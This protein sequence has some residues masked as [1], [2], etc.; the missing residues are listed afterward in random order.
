MILKRSVFY[1]SFF[2]LLATLTI[3]QAF[4]GRHHAAAIDKAEF[5]LF[6]PFSSRAFARGNPIELITSIEV[7]DA[8]CVGE[9]FPVFVN[10]VP[11]HPHDP[12]SDII[13]TI[14]GVTG[15]P[16]TLQFSELGPRFIHV[17]ASLQGDIDTQQ[18]SINIMKCTGEEIAPIIY[19]RPNPFQA[20]TI[21]FIV[22]DDGAIPATSFTWAF[23][24]GETSETS[25][26]Y[27][28]HFYGDSLDSDSSSTSFEATVNISRE[29][30][31][32]VAL[33]KTVTLWNMVYESKQQGFMQIRTITGERASDDGNS[34]IGSYTITNPEAEQIF[35]STTEREYQ[36]CDPN[37]PADTTTV[38][39][40]I[41]LIAAGQE[42]TGELT[43]N[44]SDI[45]ADICGILYR[46]RGQTEGGL[47]ADASLYFEIRQNPDTVQD[48]TNSELLD[49]LNW[50]TE[51]GLVGDED[52]VTYED[53]YELSMSGVITDTAMLM[54]FDDSAAENESSANT[55][56]SAYDDDIG[57][58]CTP[59]DTPP[60]PGLSCQVTGEWT[61]IPPH[62]ANAKKG[63]IILSS[64]CGVIG[65]LLRNVD[66]PQRY[67]HTGIM[68]ADR[69]WIRHSTASTKRYGDYGVGST[70]AGSDGIRPDILRYGW[71]GTITQ[72]V[73]E[74]FEGGFIRDPESQ[75]L[76]EIDGFNPDPIR[77][78]GEVDLTY[79]LLIKPPP[80]WEQTIRPILHQVADAA[81]QTNGHYRFG[82]YTDGTMPQNP[83]LN[84]PPE[85]GWA[86]GTIA[87]VCTTFI[88][89][90]LQ[91]VGVELEGDRLEPED[92]VQGAQV[93]S[94]T[95]DGLYFYTPTE[96]LAAGHALWKRVYNLAYEEAGW[97]GEFLTDAADDNANQVVNCFASDW[98]N[99]D[100]KDSTAWQ[101]PGVGR[102]V[103]PDNML[104]WDA[105]PVGVYGYSE[106]AIYRGSRYDR[107]YRWIPSEGT[108]NV[109]G[110]VYFEDVPVHNALVTVAGLEQFTDT[111]GVF[112]FLAVPGGNYELEASKVIDGLFYEATEDVTIE[113][114]TTIEVDLTL[115][116]PPNFYRLVTF[117]GSLKIH[118]EETI[119]GSTKTFEFYETLRLDPSNRDGNVVIEGCVDD[120]VSA[121]LEIQVQLQSDSTTVK[122]YTD[123]TLWDDDGPLGFSCFEDDDVVD[124]NV[125]DATLSEDQ[126]INVS[127]VGS[128]HFLYDDGDWADLE[129]TVSNDVQP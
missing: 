10:A 59:G 123:G 6:I 19:A 73:Y 29:G 103:S 72:S 17:A 96:R 62:I 35:V 95:A 86:A 104:F 110:V 75:K 120:E 78:S 128:N 23:G 37:Q 126:A 70:Q 26:P 108:G 89:N 45:P 69:F 53:L 115:E 101:S 109:T 2:M 57:T 42:L 50:I 76:Y 38:D 83:A 124:T 99:L 21:D 91:Q 77:C 112:Y 16:Q 105:P 79:P 80:E 18:V 117:A 43:F 39:N 65:D 93:D 122:L 119:G 81:S 46:L 87:T 64:A 4:S 61:V 7:P 20:D 125:W 14:N 51:Q 44:L 25:I 36:H 24:D 33:Q 121:R 41:N 5:Q 47:T 32:A 90:A 27:V 98:C 94:L 9:T 127:F 30:R 84:A 74:A 13:V 116:T 97:L 15:N 58:I 63:D 56:F 129:M 22:V 88:W 28:S 107:I 85:S 8:V 11:P 34:V 52:T 49:L 92:I 82:N 67:S 111:N 55:P 54:A 60:R 100:A 102:S 113:A 118:D 40:W 68:V 12:D 66:P 3:V 71:P 31:S 114:D 106:P 1:F 48:V